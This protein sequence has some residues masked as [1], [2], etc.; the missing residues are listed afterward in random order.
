MKI[1]CKKYKNYKIANFKQ[2]SVKFAKVTNTMLIFKN[3]CQKC[4]CKIFKLNFIQVL[5][6]K[7]QNLQNCEFI[8]TF[9]KEVTIYFTTLTGAKFQNSKINMGKGNTCFC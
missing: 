1:N 3:L 5:F 8:K 2:C 4:K 7:L 9:L 6:Q